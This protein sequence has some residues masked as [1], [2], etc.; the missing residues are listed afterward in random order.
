MITLRQF[1]HKPENIPMVTSWY[2][3]DL[4]EARGT[5]GASR[6]PKYQRSGVSWQRSG[7]TLEEKR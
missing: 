6:T 4:G 3:A 5:Q 2:L 7:S 1:S